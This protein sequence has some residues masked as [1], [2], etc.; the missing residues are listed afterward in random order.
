MHSRHSSN[1]LKMATSLLALFLVA[2]GVVSQEV[3]QHWAFQP[4][5][6]PAVPHV[7]DQT[8]ARN[9]ID[10]FILARLE[11]VGLKPAPLAERRTLLRRV[12]LDLIGLPPTPEELHHF[13]NDSSPFAF[14]RVVDDL[15]S[16]PQYGE[17]WATNCPNRMP[18][19]KSPPHLCAWALGTTSRPILW[20]TVTISSTM[21]WARRQRL[22]WASPSGALA[23]T[24][25]SSSHL[26]K[27]III[28]CWRCLSRSKGH[29]RAAQA[30]RRAKKSGQ[31]IRQTVGARD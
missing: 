29:D 18:R 31:R 30:N 15:L 21:S 17:R 2:G 19:C 20:S 23:A 25:T 27:K 12:Y 8:W 11:K 16:R 22:S 28:D 14:E 24:T 26:R 6:K 13:L 3:T 10:A 9:P 1:M 5:Q 7:S 4:V